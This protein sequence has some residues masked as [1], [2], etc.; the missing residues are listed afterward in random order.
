MP[1][2]RRKKA[3]HDA[4]IPAFSTLF[5]ITKEITKIAIG[6]ETRNLMTDAV[7]HLVISSSSDLAILYRAMG[8]FSDLSTCR[9]QKTPLTSM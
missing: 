2:G 8:S 9:V 6:I 4:A 7:L 1:G 3:G 5:V